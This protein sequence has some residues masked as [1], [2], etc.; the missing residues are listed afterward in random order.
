M[1]SERKKKAGMAPLLPT[2]SAVSCASES[3]VFDRLYERGLYLQQKLDER[4]RRK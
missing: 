1:G 2:S 3:S 4:R